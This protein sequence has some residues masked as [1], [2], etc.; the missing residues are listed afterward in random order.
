MGKAQTGLK[1]TMRGTFSNL[2][3]DENPTIEKIFT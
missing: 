2:K 1:R 3:M